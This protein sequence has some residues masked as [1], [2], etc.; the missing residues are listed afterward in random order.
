[1]SII[2]SNNSSLTVGTDVAIVSEAKLNG[3]SERIRL[4]IVNTSS[5]GQ[6]ISVHVDSEA[7]ANSG[8]FLYPG[9][10]ISWT[11]DSSMMPIQQNRVTAISSAAGGTISI[12]EEVIN[13]G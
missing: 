11:K 12:Y 1:V 13:R 4:I 7:V 2:A 6:N 10:S 3:Y 9:G 8:I 5:A